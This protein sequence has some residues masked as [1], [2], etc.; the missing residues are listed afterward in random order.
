MFLPGR[1]DGAVVVAA[2]P[3]ILASLNDIIMEINSTQIK[4]DNIFL[5]KPIMI[6][7]GHSAN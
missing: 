4:S 3:R 1:Y 6:T 7:D 5:E 2:T